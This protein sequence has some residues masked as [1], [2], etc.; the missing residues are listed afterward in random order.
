LAT[1]FEVIFLGVPPVDIDPTEGNTT[2]ENAGA[3]VGRTFGTAGDP[4]YG[5][6]QTL[7][8]VGNPGSAY[9]LDNSSTNEQFAVN[10]TPYTM[11]GW[12]VYNAT[13][14][15]L[16]GTT[17]TVEVKIAQTTTG[18]AYLVPHLPGDTAKTTVLAAQPIQSL[19]LTSLGT[20]GYSMLSD[21]TPDSFRQPVEGINGADSIGPGYTDAQGSRVTNRADVVRA[22][23]GN[24]TIAAGAGNDL[25][26]TGTGADVVVLDV[27]AGRDTITDFDMTRV[28]GRTVDQLDISGLTNPDGSPISW[29]DVVVTDTNGDGTGH[30]LLRFP[31]GESLVLQGVTPDQVQGWEAMTA[32]GIPCFVTGTSILTANGPR[33]VENIVPGD[34][35]QTDTGLRPVIWAGSRHL[36]AQDLAAN[37]AQRPIHFAPGAIGNTSALRLSPQHAVLLHGRAPVLARA[38]HLEQ[39]GLPGVRIAAGVRQVTYHHLLLDRHSIL[40][41]AGARVESMYPGP[42]IMA[43]L[44]PADRL[45]IAVAIAGLRRFTLQ[46][47]IDLGDL[48]QAYG[49]RAYPLLP[50]DAVARLCRGT[51]FLHRRAERVT[52]HRQAR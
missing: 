51:G 5:R 18:E 32:M 43:L 8:P 1:T 36:T 38:K 20:P 24:D 9:D 25:I 27:G 26:T 21:R 14:T 45:R 17:A 31:N 4:L 42:Q 50:R 6:V 22:G 19:T 41:A 12:G 37:P 46:R 47:L 28:A 49:P 13:I 48:S 15:Y 16:D 3:L 11:D 23:G 29:Q 35:V 34:L 30:A 40:Q 2:S 7:S 39:S 33:P 10:G 44:A 52:D